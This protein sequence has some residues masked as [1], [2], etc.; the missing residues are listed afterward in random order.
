[1]PNMQGADLGKPVAAFR[2]RKGYAQIRMFLLL[3]QAQ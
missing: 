2:K 1:M 3:Q